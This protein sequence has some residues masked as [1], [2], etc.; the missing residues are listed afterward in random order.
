MFVDQRGVTIEDFEANFKLSKPHKNLNYSIPTMYLPPRSARG[1]FGP[2]PA[3]AAFEAL[4]CNLETVMP[5]TTSPQLGVPGESEP[6]GLL[7]PEAY[8]TMS[9]NP[10]S[11]SSS[12]VE[13]E[14]YSPGFFQ[15]EYNLLQNEPGEGLF[16]PSDNP[17]DFSAN[18]LTQFLDEAGSFTFVDIANP[19]GVF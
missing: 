7:S 3:E 1:T 4:N 12:A 13:P 17:A 15:S 6:E 8:P 14:S 19:D 5:G 9:L 16:D 18:L 10:S 2:M 11:P